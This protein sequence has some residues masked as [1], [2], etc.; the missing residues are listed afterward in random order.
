M[1]F[2][3]IAFVPIFLVEHLQL[4]PSVF[5]CNRSMVIL[6]PRSLVNPRHLIFCALESIPPH[7]VPIG[8]NLGKIKLGLGQDEQP[9][10][11]VSG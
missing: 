8:S 6:P 1:C 4:V 3:G 10:D 9:S 2:A 7:I 11:N 5:L